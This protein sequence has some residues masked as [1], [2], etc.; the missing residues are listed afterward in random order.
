M[1]LCGPTGTDL[2]HWGIKWTQIGMKLKIYLLFFHQEKDTVQAVIFA[3][4]LLATLTTTKAE[5]KATV[6]P[7]T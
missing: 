4:I 5:G 7:I 6:K 2:P 1:K 3:T